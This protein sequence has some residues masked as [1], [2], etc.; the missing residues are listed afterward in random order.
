MVLGISLS[1]LFSL[2]VAFS[3]RP[4]L[5]CMLVRKAAR[6]PQILSTLV[7]SASEENISVMVAASAESQAEAVR[8]GLWVNPFQLPVYSS[9]KWGRLTLGRVA[10]I[11]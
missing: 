2:L 9:V 1:L 6:S 10:G 4:S 7:T 5:L 3:E 8:S 11:K